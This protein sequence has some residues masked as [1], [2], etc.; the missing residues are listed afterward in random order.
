MRRAI[1][2][3]GGDVDAIGVSSAGI[4]I[5][6]KAMVASLFIKVGK[7]DFDKKVKVCFLN[8]YFFILR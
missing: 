6:N 2:K 5:D 1:D 7:E 3:L 4:Y 8:L